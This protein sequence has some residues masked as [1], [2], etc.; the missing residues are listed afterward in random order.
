M[1]IHKPASDAIAGLRSVVDAIKDE[2]PLLLSPD[3]DD[4]LTR[5]VQARGTPA[6]IEQWARRLAADVSDLAD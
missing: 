3:L 4:L 2:R 1:L 5:A 6:D